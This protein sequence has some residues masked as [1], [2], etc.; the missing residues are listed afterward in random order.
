MRS[1]NEKNAETKKQKKNI[2]FARLQQIREKVKE[3]LFLHICFFPL[4]PV[5]IC[6]VLTS[7]WK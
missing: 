6:L 4:S 5:A 3:K 1:T 7:N 2:P